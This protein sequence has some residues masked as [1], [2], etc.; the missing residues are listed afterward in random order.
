MSVDAIRFELLDEPALPHGESPVATI[1]F[2]QGISLPLNF[3]SMGLGTPPPPYVMSDGETRLWAYRLY[4][5]QPPRDPSVKAEE[6][7]T[8][9][10]AVVS[11]ARGKPRTSNESSIR[12]RPY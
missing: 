5:D 2:G 10:R 7:R 11:F 4:T 8:R 12:L 9:I 3:P 6:D 1:D